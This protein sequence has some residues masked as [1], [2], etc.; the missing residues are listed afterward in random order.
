MNL[1]VLDL[2]IELNESQVLDLQIE[3][4]ESQS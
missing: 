2:Q 3:L 4:N 1:K